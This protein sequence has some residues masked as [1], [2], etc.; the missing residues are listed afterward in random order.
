MTHTIEIGH[1]FETAHRLSSPNAPVKC[2]SIHGHSWW[3]TLTIAADSLDDDGMVIEFGALKKAWRG[4]L[5]DNVDHHLVVESEDPVGAAI[6]SVQPDAR[7]LRLPFQPTTELLAQWLFD[8]AER[9]LS[10]LAPGAPAKV[11]HVHLQETRVNA[12]TYQKD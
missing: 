4:F 3:V 8:Q 1:N 12:A 6:L 11:V 7:L 10:E 9:I 5:D 2:Q